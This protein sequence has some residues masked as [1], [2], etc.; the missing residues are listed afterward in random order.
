[1]PVTTP[2]A[3]SPAT[4]SDPEQRLLDSLSRKYAQSQD[5]GRVRGYILAAAILMLLF[6][7]AR[8]VPWWGVALVVVEAIGLLL[9]RQYK[10]FAH[11]K[12]RLL[13]KLW[14]MRE[15]R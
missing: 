4:L 9:F 8:W 1:M 14:T 10:R 11:F 2:A 3:T 12:T 15:A 5:A 6:A 13:V 7:V